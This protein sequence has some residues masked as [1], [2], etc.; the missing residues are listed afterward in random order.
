LLEDIAHGTILAMLRWVEGVFQRPAV[1]NTL[2]VF[3]WIIIAF[4][5]GLFILLVYAIC[6]GDLG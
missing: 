5:F 6:I 2:E 4:V 3:A 1:G